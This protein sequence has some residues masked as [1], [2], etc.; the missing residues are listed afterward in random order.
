MNNGVP[1]STARVSAFRLRRVYRWLLSILLMILAVAEYSQAGQDHP[2]LLILNSYHQGEDWTD[3]EMSGVVNELHKYYPNLTPSVEDLDA[4]RFPGSEHL[5]FFKNYLLG[6]YRN[7]TFDLIIALDNPALELLATNSAE[8][9]PETPVVFAGINGY[10][11]GM[12]SGRKNVTGVMENQ[13]VAG[14]LKMA[15][16]LHPRISTVLAI[17]DYTTSGL[18]VRQEAESA[19]A[20]M[21]DK[22]DIRYSANAPFEVLRQQLAA[23]PANSLVLILTYV[24]DQTGHT[25]S[26]EESTRLITTNSPVPVYAMHETRLGFGIVGGILLEGREHGRQAADIAMRILRGEKPAQIT[27]EES[28]SRLVLDYEVVSRFQIPEEL[29]PPDAILINRPQS[30]WSRHRTILLPAIAIVA[31]LIAFSTMLVFLLMRMH[32]TERTLR[33]SEERFRASFEEDSIGRTLTGIDGRLL[34][35]NSLFCAMLGYTAEEIATMRFSD[36]THPDDL[37]SSQEAVRCLLSGEQKSYRFEKRYLHKD[38]SHLWMEVTTTLLRDETGTPQY[39][40]TGILDISERKRASE[41]LRESEANHKLVLAMMQESLSVI[42]IDGNILLANA[43]AARNL[44]GGRV[45]ELI[46]RN[47]RQIVPQ[48]QSVKLLAAYRQVLDSG[49]PLTQEVRLS[50]A[51]GDRWFFNTLQPLEYGEGR[52]KA[53]LSISLDISDRKKAEEALRESEEKFRQMT[54]SVR[55]VFWLGS[56]DWKEMHYIS[57]AYATVWGKDVR[58]LYDNPLSWLDQVIDED[59]EKVKK[60]IPSLIGKDTSPIIFPDY[61]IRKTD[62][63]YAWISAKAFPVLD[64]D[65]SPY[66]I[67]GIAEDITDRKHAEERL[68]ESEARLR[69]S[70]HHFR[71]LANSDLALIW[72]S[73]PDKLC[74]YFNE[75]W[76]RFTGRSLEQELGDGWSE[77]VH[78]EDLDRCLNIYISHFESRKPFSMEYRLRKANGEYGWILDLGNPRHD[79]DGN[80]VGYIG[81]CYDISERKH[82][83]EERRIL[84]AQLQQAQKMEAIGTLA[85]GIAHD[86]NNILGAIIGYSEMIRDDFP[87]NSP[88]IHDIDQV[89]KAS[90]RAKD[91]VKQI[92]DFSH[93]GEDQ[94]IPIQPAAIVKEAITL[95]R[96]SLPTTITIA[97]DIDPGAGIILA[98]PTQIHQIVM[99]LSTNAFHAMETKGGTLTI[100]LRQKLLSRDDLV[101]EP[102]LQPGR[103][104]QLSI[105]DTGEGILPEIRARIFD[106]FFTTKEVGKGTGLGLSMVYS[107]VKSCHG[108]IACDSQMGEGTEFRI[109][110]PA[111]E[112]HYTEESAAITPIPHGK[113]HILFIDDEEM[114]VEMGQAMLERLGYHVTTRTNS[115]D[116]LMTFQNQQDAFDLVITD[117]TMPGMTGIDLARRILQIRPQMPIILCTGYSSLITEDKAKAVGVKG[118]AFKPLTKK[119]LGELIRKVL[120]R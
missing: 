107:I 25:F 67:A 36:I 100:A 53:V 13:D 23:M 10:H 72:T 37:T 3:N 83:E 111:L 48:D 49:T 63:S 120:E 92:L 97:Q 33:I 80:F 69:E 74:N 39:F 52:V 31:L 27:V 54:E 57:P 81:F 114:L 79:S 18:A 91:L 70:E 90:H 77:G 93:L 71:T 115:L 26:R 17:H 2:R 15:L 61:R 11:P 58:D 88:S 7:A 106:P 105:R 96:S 94:K 84:N 12:L 89:L 82:A 119:E 8:L 85:G 5:T 101:T 46:G 50:L 21:A 19:M 42:D 116:A 118:F 24:T 35:V 20:T 75:P 44:A 34:R 51:Q 66:R 62:G 1:A 98:D 45:E 95:L 14:T 40:I 113:E 68:K 108:A 112:G 9:F 41:A 87:A 103:F 64:A 109:L 30:L 47:I 60:A 117:Q 16:G 104:V 4:K 22:V 55:D 29:L 110:L 32:R 99:N 76:L 59:K 102:D 6:K 43:T 86:F 38:G 65:G 73:G 78:P 56:L 28:R